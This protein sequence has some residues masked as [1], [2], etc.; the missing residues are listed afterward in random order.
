MNPI[1]VK[2]EN[3]EPGRRASFKGGEKSPMAP[4]E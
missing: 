3:G 2:N 1:Q 4:C